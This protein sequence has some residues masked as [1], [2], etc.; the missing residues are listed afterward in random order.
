MSDLMGYD[1][2]FDVSAVYSP[3]SFSYIDPKASNLAILR[4][5]ARRLPAH[6]RRRRQADRLSPPVQIIDDSSSSGFSTTGAGRK[7]PADTT[8]NR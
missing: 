5:A 6:F 2:V 3:T 8:A 7:L 1:G 4:A